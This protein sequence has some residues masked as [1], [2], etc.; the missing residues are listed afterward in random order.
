MSRLQSILE[1]E[2]TDA[3]QAADAAQFGRSLTGLSGKHGSTDEV[4]YGQKLDPSFMRV[5]SETDE[6]APTLPGVNAAARGRTRVAAAQVQR[7]RKPFG[8][9]NQRLAYPARPGYRRYWFND[10]PGRLRQA[11]EAGYDHVAD[12]ETGGPVAIVVGRQQGGQE[13][14][15]Y[16][17]EIPEEWYFEDMG[18]Q[19][20]LLERHLSE[21]RTGR[22]GP[23]ADENRYVPQR[24]I[25]FG[26]KRTA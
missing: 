8:G 24:G 10:V 18:A 15:S 9:S 16:L 21:I 4:I 12:P 20:E 7:E 3:R 25:S 14:K 11:K 2:N 23:G 19:Q 13:L 22:S 5:E 1:G 17:L 6:A 26:G